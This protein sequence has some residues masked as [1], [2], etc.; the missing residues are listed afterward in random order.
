[1][2]NNQLS[3]Q[4]LIDNIK[5]RNDNSKTALAERYYGSLTHIAINPPQQWVK[6][7]AHQTG[8]THAQ[9]NRIFVWDTLRSQALPLT[10]DAA[11]TLKDI[12]ETE[13]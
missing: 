6:K 11:Y 7:F 1:M 8:L 3:A 10:L 4:A 2:K 12:E 13:E 5:Q 9:I